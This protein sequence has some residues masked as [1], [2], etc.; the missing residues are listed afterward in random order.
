MSNVTAAD[1]KKLRDVTG[2]GMMDCKVALT[3][4]GGDLDK[5]RAILRERGLADAA[6]RK[7]RDATDGLIVSYLHAPTPGV[8]A[9]VGVLLELSTETDFVAKTDDIR[10]LAQGLVLHI[11]A[12][13]PLYLTSEEVPQ[14]ELDAERDLAGKKVEGKPEHVV[15]KAQEGAV[16]KYL[17]SVV[18]LEQKWIKDDK[19]TVRE[20]VDTVAGKLGENLGVRR[21][22]RYEVA[23]SLD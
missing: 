5:A 2:A 13:K 19:Q 20:V 3:E 6:K 10:D 11:A 14:N 23:E 7:G 22:V 16:R 21:F 1:V 8:P 17:Q 4:S 9:K 12:S 15:E 18:L